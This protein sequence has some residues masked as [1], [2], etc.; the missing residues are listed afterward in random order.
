[1]GFDEQPSQSGLKDIL[2]G[3]AGFAP[4]IRNGDVFEQTACLRPVTQDGIPIVG[5]LMAKRRGYGR[6]PAQARRAYC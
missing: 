5:P 3:A 4:I 6:W 1:M 2:D